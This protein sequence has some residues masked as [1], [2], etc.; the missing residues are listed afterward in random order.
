MN[1]CHDGLGRRSVPAS[2]KGQKAQEQ[3][4]HKPRDATTPA[5]TKPRSYT[6]TAETQ[7]HRLQ[8]PKELGVK[9]K[10]QRTVPGGEPTAS[11][12]PTVAPQSPRHPQNAARDLQAG[13]P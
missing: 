8:D 3:Q 2:T 7:R 5:S 13:S 12:R 6:Q 9:L 4:T 1:A 10:H 11:Q